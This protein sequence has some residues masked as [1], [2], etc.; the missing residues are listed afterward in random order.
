MSMLHVLSSPSFKQEQLKFYNYKYYT[1]ALFVIYA[2]FES[3]LESINRQAQQTTYSQQHKVC[4]AAA[5]LCSTLGNYNQLT[6]MKV[7]DN[8]LAEFLDVL[9]KWETAIVEELRMNRSMKRMSAQKREDYENAT[10][11][12]IY[13]QPFEEDDPKGAKVRDQDHITGFCIG[14]AH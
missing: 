6:V 14:A 7:G 13:R 2:D 5:V 11:C 4:A 1:L 8:A 10:E 3:I 12:Y 9:N